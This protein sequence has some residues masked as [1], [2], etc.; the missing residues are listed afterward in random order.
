M[1]SITEIQ[2]AIHESRRR[3]G[4]HYTALSEELNL[5]M[6]LRNSIQKRP[7]S[8]IGSAF[9]TG[10]ITGFF[11]KNRSSSACAKESITSPKAP[12][13]LKQISSLSSLLLGE[14][15]LALAAGK[16]LRFLFPLVQP[17]ITQYVT[18]KLSTSQKEHHVMKFRS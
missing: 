5:K 6:R 17:I 1:K 15:T 12:S 2:I 9:A 18:E 4:V 13:F 16:F 10:M 3:I 8:W 14:T 11:K 7:W